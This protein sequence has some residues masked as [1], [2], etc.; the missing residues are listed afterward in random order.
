MTT[1]ATDK[2][3]CTACQRPRH[4]LKPRKSKLNPSMQMFLCGEC[5]EAK[6]EPRWLIILIAR[7]ERL[8]G[9][10]AVRDHIRNRKYFGD[11]ITADEIVT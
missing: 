3:K 11:K 7:D 1:N 8:G 6:R 4:S 9:F 10:K 5:L 2:V